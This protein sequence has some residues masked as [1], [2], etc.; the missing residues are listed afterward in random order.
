MGINEKFIE[1][2]KKLYVSGQST[3]ILTNQGPHTSQVCKTIKRLIEDCSNFKQSSLVKLLPKYLNYLEIIVQS[4][5]N[6]Q[7][8]QDLG[9]H[10][11]LIKII[12]YYYDR[13]DLNV[14]YYLTI[15]NLS[16]IMSK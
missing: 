12:V 13:D 7:K 3:E 2:C 14:V 4:A 5:F 9:I 1:N 10:L 11:V 15:K 16:I 6:H 8:M